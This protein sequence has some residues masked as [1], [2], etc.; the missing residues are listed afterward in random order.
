MVSTMVSFRGANWISQPSTVRSAKKWS[1]PSERGGSF[2]TTLSYIRNPGV[3]CVSKTPCNQ[4]GT[5][6]L[7]HSVLPPPSHGPCNCPKHPWSMEPSPVV[8]FTPPDLPPLL[9]EASLDAH[10]AKLEPGHPRPQNTSSKPQV[11]RW[12]KQS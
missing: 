6:P 10:L 4:F 3:S 1:G 5:K 7:N 2:Y 12:L 9:H 11:E 8:L